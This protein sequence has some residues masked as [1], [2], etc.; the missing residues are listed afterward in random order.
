M[1]LALSDHLFGLRAS[2][3]K[4]PVMVIGASRSGPAGAQAPAGFFM[5]GR[6]NIMVCF[7]CHAAYLTSIVVIEM[8]GFIFK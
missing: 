2:S 6:D 7:K 3:A 5:V 4:R 1:R 8:K